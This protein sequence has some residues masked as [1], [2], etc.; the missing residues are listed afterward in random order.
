VAQTVTAPCRLPYDP[1]SISPGSLLC[2]SEHS[3]AI[4]DTCSIN[5][6]GHTQSDG[7]AHADSHADAD[8]YSHGYTNS[9]SDASPDDR[10]DAPAGL[11]RQRDHH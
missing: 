4:A 7:H 10:G 6:N 1:G 5:V 11:S 2:S 3:A 8:G 9:H